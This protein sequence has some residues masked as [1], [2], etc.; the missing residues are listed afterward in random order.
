M[1][2]IERRDTRLDGGITLFTPVDL[3]KALYPES[4]DSFM[5]KKATVEPKCHCWTPKQSVYVGCA[6]GQLLTIESDSGVTKILAN[7]QLTVCYH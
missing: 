6:G 2:K 1:P 7:P 3:S 4:Y 5:Q